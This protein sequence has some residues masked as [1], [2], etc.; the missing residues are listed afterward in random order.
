MNVPILNKKGYSYQSY[1]IVSFLTQE[2]RRD[3]DLSKQSKMV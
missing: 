3:V 2:A 1:A